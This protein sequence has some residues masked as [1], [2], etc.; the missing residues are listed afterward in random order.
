VAQGEVCDPTGDVCCAGTGCYNGGGAG[1]ECRPSAM[2]HDAELTHPSGL[3]HAARTDRHSNMWLGANC[4]TMAMVA[5]ALSAAL[6]LVVLR[7]CC[8]RRRQMAVAANAKAPLL[9]V[10]NKYKAST[11]IPVPVVTGTIVAVLV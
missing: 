1:Y 2:L 10:E 7:R 4:H 3:G 9:P 8:R 6:L 11:S 5:A